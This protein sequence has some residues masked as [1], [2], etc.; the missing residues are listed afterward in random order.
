M[1]FYT[2]SHQ[3][4]HTSCE[5]LLLLLLLIP[6][7]RINTSRGTPLGKQGKQNVPQSSHRRRS[8]HRNGWTPDRLLHVRLHRHWRRQG[9]P[10]VRQALLCYPCHP[11]PRNHGTERWPPPRLLQHQRQFLHHPE[12]WLLPVLIPSRHSHT[13]GCVAMV[14]KGLGL[15]RK[16][17][18]VILHV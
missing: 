13:L 12:R 9:T 11:G 5:L 16:V 8:T 3:L 1:S 15:T 14:D 4:L 6:W 2:R 10:H 17:F 7:L 18:I